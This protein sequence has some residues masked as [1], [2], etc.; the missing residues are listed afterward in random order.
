M[1][2]WCQ[3]SLSRVN[4]KTSF[5]GTLKTYCSCQTNCFY[6]H[7]LQ[8]AFLKYR[9]KRTNMIRGNKRKRIGN[10]IQHVMPFPC[11]FWQYVCL[12][13]T[14][15]SANYIGSCFNPDC[16]WRSI[17]IPPTFAS[18][19]PC[20][21]ALWDIPLPFTS[22]EGYSEPNN[23]DS[24]AF[25]LEARD[26]FCKTHS[27]WRLQISF[28]CVKMTLWLLSISRGPIWTWLRWKIYS[29]RPLSGSFYPIFLKLDGKQN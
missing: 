3:H 1:N 22:Y 5:Q 8:Y 18:Y 10:N 14:W 20:C 26:S 12:L 21:E 7:G 11:K 6:S 24:V 4:T 2:L 17:C 19:Q 25:T 23:L 27:L 28:W 15:Y 16:E 9:W 13:S 29:I